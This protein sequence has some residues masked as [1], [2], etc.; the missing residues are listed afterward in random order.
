MTLK[1][2]RNIILLVLTSILIT[3]IIPGVFS[4]IGGTFYLNDIKL[5]ISKSQSNKLTEFDNHNAFVE[6][7]IQQVDNKIN[8]FLID[9]G[10][11]SVLT[12]DELIKL[13]D[14]LIFEKQNAKPPLSLIPYY[15]NPQMLLWLGIYAA[16][17]LL[18]YLLLSEQKTKIIFTRRLFGFSILVYVFYEWPLWLRN[19]VLTNNGRTV[20]AYPNYD[21]DK[22]SYFYQEFIIY[23]FCLLATILISVSLQLYNS[24]VKVETEDND[25]NKFLIISSYY[26]TAYRNWFIH[27]T[28][29]A[30]GFLSFT[31][32]FW[33]LVFAYGDQRYVISALNA[34]VLWAL[35]WVAISLNLLRF[36]QQ[37]DKTKREILRSNPDDKTLKIV[38]E[39]QPANNMTL[40]ISGIASL[41]TFLLPLLKTLLQ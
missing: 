15:L 31:G 13:K 41:V 29:L 22:Y 37:F 33:R 39:H 19:F 26:S 12:I 21:I 25:T 3:V 6:T 27:S 30:L 36:M 2:F 5:K 11:K 40:I 9:T 34:H 35:C 32:F 16:F 24:K 28:I 38:M 7:L 18:I 14:K 10:Q 20:Y 1:D 4:S 23:F 17:F 8:T